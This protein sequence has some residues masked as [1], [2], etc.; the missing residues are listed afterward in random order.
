MTKS[1]SI[2]N[3]KW[4]RGGES[5]RIQVQQGSLGG[6]VYCVF[7]TR[8]KQIEKVDWLAASGLFL[9]LI[10]LDHQSGEA[11]DDISVRT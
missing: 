1:L 11:I 2:Q 6:I 10:K 7:S 5:K 8:W 3:F 4:G 9:F